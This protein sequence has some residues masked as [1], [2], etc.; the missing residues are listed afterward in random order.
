MTCGNGGPSGWDG[1][2]LHVL[3]DGN[4]VASETMLNIGSESFFIPV[5]IG[6]R[7]DVVYNEDGWGQYHDYS[8][9]DSDGN[10]VFSSDDW[11]APGD[12]PCSV[13]G[14]EPCEDMSSCGLMEVTFFDEDGYGWYAGGMAFYSDEGLES[15][16]FFN[17]DF[18][19]DG[20]YDYDGFSSRTA[21]VNVWE[22]E[23]DFVVIMPVA[24]AD[25][26]GYQV[27][28][29]DGDLVVEDN[30]LGQLPGN[31]LNV[32]VCEPATSATTNLG[33]ERAPLR[34]HP[35]PTAASFQLQGFQ[36]QE[37]WQVQLV[38]L[39]GQ[40]ILERSGVGAEPVSVEGLPSGLYHVIV[41]FG[42][43]E[44]QGFRLVKE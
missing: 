6:D 12:D 41:Q 34:L 25:Q 2:Y 31:A 1:A 17:P 15:Q 24:Y 44:A 38:G 4:E 43:G 9:A 40:R 33:T 11:G 20:Y 37:P 5:D 42:E 7:I 29:P 32:V 13:Y 35:N 19:G 3:V 18:D 23:V 10:V 21:M 22:G 28:N 16:I 27:K 8:I 14:L 26:C 36:G 39:D 30:V